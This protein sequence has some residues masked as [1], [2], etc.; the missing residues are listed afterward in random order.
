MGGSSGYDKLIAK[1]KTG[2]QQVIHAPEGGF[3]GLS[4]KFAGLFTPW[5]SK[6]GLVPL[7]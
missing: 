7:F 6:F 1:N 5:L 3:L 4:R 2:Q